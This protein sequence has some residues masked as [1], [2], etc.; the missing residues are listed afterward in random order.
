MF[1]KSESGHQ[2]MSVSDKSESNENS[3][4]NNS[5]Q[6]KREGKTN[7]E[8][9]TGETENNRKVEQLKTV[10]RVAENSQDSNEIEHDE[11]QHIND[12]QDNYKLTLDNAT[13]K[14]SKQINHEDE[15]IEDENLEENFIEVEDEQIS[16][17]NIKHFDEI[18]K[19]SGEQKEKSGEGLTNEVLDIEGEEIETTNVLRGTETSAHFQKHIVT[20]KSFVEDLST[21]QV[22]YLRKKIIAELTSNNNVSIPY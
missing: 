2:G 5:E 16:E 22:T 6:K 20:D 4:M 3:K 7:E 13:E 15:S 9:S 11:Y 10:D 19:K 14:Q 1:K 12:A 8:R 18:E 17:V 21:Q